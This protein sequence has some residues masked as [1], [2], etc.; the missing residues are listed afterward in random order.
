MSKSLRSAAIRTAHSH[1]G[2]VRDALLPILKRTAA[3]TTL[4]QAL[5]I[6]DSVLPRG[7]KIKPGSPEAKKMEGFLDKGADV[8]AVVDIMESGE[9]D[10]SGLT[11]A[12]KQ[13]A[14]MLNKL[15]D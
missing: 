8:Q 1:P 6:L 4:D 15:M 2:P 9:G 7:V 10:F 14:D 5:D 3:K 12:T 13:L 11:G